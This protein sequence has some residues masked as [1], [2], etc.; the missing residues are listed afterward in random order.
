MENHWFSLWKI[1]CSDMP[2]PCVHLEDNL[3]CCRKHHPS[4]QITLVFAG[5]TSSS[6]SIVTPASLQRLSPDSRG[7]YI[8]KFNGWANE[9]ST[10]ETSVSVWPSNIFGVSLCVQFQFSLKTNSEQNGMLQDPF[11][12]VPN[13]ELESFWWLSIQIIQSIQLISMGTCQ[14]KQSGDAAPSNELPRVRVGR[15]VLR[16]FMTAMSSGSSQGR[17]EWHGESGFR[18]L[19]CSQINANQLF[20]RCDPN[21]CSETKAD[22]KTF[23]E[24]HPLF[25]SK[26]VEPKASSLTTWSILSSCLSWRRPRTSLMSRYHIVLPHIVY[27]P[28]GKLT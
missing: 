26:E 15:M 6:S 25:P 17:L 14:R 24:M 7:W 3:H 18:S 27:I 9:K 8:P 11:K 13:I 20:H 2:C 12:W 16:C 28:S 22:R 21:R 4:F 5:C 1:V 10:V 23:E 19:L